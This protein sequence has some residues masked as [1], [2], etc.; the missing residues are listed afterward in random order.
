MAKWIRVNGEG[1]YG[2]RPWMQAGE[3]PSQVVIDHFKENTVDWT[4]ED[5]RFTSKGNAVYAFQMKWPEGGRTVIRSMAGGKVGRVASV[6]L[7]G[8]KEAL[9][10]EQ[11]ERGLV[12]ALP[13][14]KSSDYTQCLK[15]VFE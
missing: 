11:T 2:T 9:Q 8:V 13:A 12:I 10:F 5:F 6:E 15:V 1:I 3:G 4:I 14:Q 7:L